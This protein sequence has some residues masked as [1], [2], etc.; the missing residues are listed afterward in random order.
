M[1]VP[2]PAAAATAVFFISFHTNFYCIRFCCY[3][4]MYSHFVFITVAVFLNVLASPRTLTAFSLPSFQTSGIF[5]SFTQRWQARD[6]FRKLKCYQRIWLLHRSLW[7]ITE[8]LILFSWNFAFA[9][10]NWSNS[11]RITPTKQNSHTQSHKNKSVSEWPIVIFF[12]LEYGICEND[13][14]IS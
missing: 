3:F 8:I 9:I 1:N 6:F 4:P 10:K 12:C 5:F 7:I 13:F 14:T 11:M 2:S